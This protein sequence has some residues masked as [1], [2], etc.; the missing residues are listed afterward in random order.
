MLSQPKFES[1]TN[2]AII[3]HVIQWERSLSKTFRE[4]LAGTHYIGIKFAKASCLAYMHNKKIELLNALLMI[5]PTK[6]LCPYKC[7]KQ[8]YW[9]KYLLQ[10][11]HL[12]SLHR[13]NLLG[14]PLI[15]MGN[16]IW[17]ARFFAK[18]FPVFKKTWNESK[19]RCSLFWNMTKE[20][21]FQDSIAKR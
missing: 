11:K 5:P 18:T 9:H 14:F 13:V 19:R 15:N 8:L 17:D 21:N 3:S 10:S 1:W 7:I 12:K 4:I 6:F 20:I 16:Q 2:W